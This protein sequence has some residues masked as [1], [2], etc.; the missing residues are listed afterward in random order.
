VYFTD[1]TGAVLSGD[2]TYVFG[3]VTYSYTDGVPVIIANPAGAGNLLTYPIFLKFR[4]TEKVVLSPFIFSEQHEYET[5]LYG[6]S[7]IQLLCNI[8]NAQRVIRSTTGG[9]RTISAIQFNA[10]KSSAFEDARLDC[11]F[12]TPPLSLSL[13]RE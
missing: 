12:L 13:P 1:S 2:G 8:S 11:I 7:N 4:S 9:G 5:G 3:G 10:Q 6:L